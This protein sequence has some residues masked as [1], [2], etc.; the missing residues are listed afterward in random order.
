MSLTSRLVAPERVSRTVAWAFLLLFGAAALASLGLPGAVE[1]AGTQGAAADV[2]GSAAA[3][4][5]NAASVVR[6]AAEVA[7]QATVRELSKVVRAMLEWQWWPF[8][9]SL[10]SV[11][12]FGGANVFHS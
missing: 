5:A 9:L 11:H 8:E 7:W 2:I 10:G 3:S 4:L 6:S 1:S 12:L